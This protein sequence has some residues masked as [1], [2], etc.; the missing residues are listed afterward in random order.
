LVLKLFGKANDRSHQAAAENAEQVPDEADPAAVVV[1]AAPGAPDGPR[2]RTLV[3][4]LAVARRPLA[5]LAARRVTARVGT[6]KPVRLPNLLALA[7]AVVLIAAGGSALA[8]TRSAGQPRMAAKRVGITGVAPAAAALPAGPPVRSAGASSTSTS[9]RVGS[10]AANGT[11]IVQG[12]SQ[13]VGGLPLSVNQD[14]AQ[15]TTGAHSAGGPAIT[16]P[17]PTAAT[18][19]KVPGVSKDHTPDAVVMLSSP[20]TGPQVAALSHLA[21]VTA[22]ETVDSGTVTMGGAPVVAFGVDPGTFRDFTPAA[23]AASDQ[24]WNY[25]AGGSFV[26]S[27]DMA[28]DRALK[29]GSIQ[30]IVPSASAPDSKVTGWLGGFAAIGLPGVDLLVDHNYSLQLGLT[31]DSGLVVVAP[32]LSGTKLQAELSGAVPDGVVELLYADQ[33]P[34]NLVGDSLTS[35]V[36]QRIVAAALSRIGTP[37]VWGGAAPGGFDCSGLVQW[38]YRQAGVLMPRVADEQFLTGDHIPLADAQ[39]GDLVFWAYDPSDPGYI[40]HVGIYLGNGMMVVAPYTGTDVQIAPVTS[41]DF[42]GAVQVVLA[43]Q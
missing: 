22:I 26:S 12:L 18:L 14:P 36:R 34:T 19:P 13:P 21:G 29:L 3:S 33:L 24:L 37:Y 20:L 4:T 6:R 32:G 39:P 25:L 41:N 2:R 30:T 35:T 5:G 38:S 7:V 23:S 42:A 16:I 27:Y 17:T 1:E 31:P 8:V 43:N 28:N 15:I 11:S 10:P 9:S 40:D